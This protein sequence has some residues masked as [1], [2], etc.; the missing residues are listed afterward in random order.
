[1]SSG[2]AVV[3]ASERTLWTY[4]LFRNLELYGY[5]GEI[6]PVNPS[7]PE[8]FGRPC[9]ADLDS[10]PGTPETGV[11]VV[12]P[13]LA[14]DAC[15]R[16]VELGSRT[17]IVVS[18]GFRESGTDV[19]INAEREMVEICRTAGVRMIG[20]NCVGYASFHDNMC[21]IAEPVPPALRAGDVTLASHSGAMISGVLGAL[22]VEALGIDH[23]FSIGNAALFDMAEA[24][25]AGVDSDATRII[26]AVVEGIPPRDQLERVIAAGHSA[27]KEFVFLLLAQSAGGQKVA[28]SHTGAVIGEQRVARAWLR[29]LGV[30]VTSSVEEMARA[31]NIVRSTGRPRPGTGAFVVTASGG[32]AGLASDLAE[33]HEVPLANVSDKTLETMRTALPAGAYAGNPLDMVAGIA[34]EARAELFRAVGSDPSVG[35]L[36][37]PYT[38]TWPDDSPGRSWHRSGF[39]DFAHQCASS[40]LPGIVCSIYDEPLT[41]WMIE[42]RDRTGLCVLGGLG[43][44]MAA[45]GAIYRTDTTPLP[46]SPPGDTS[47]ATVIGEAEGRALLVEAGLAVV[48]GEKVADSEAATQVAAG[49]PGPWVLKLGLAGVGHKGRVGGVRVGLWGR[50]AVQRAGREIA[51]SAVAAGLAD[52]PSAVPFLLQ[53]M[54]TGPEI[55]LG[56]VRDPIAGPSVTVSVGGWA[57]EGSQ[58]FGTLTLPATDGEIAQEFHNWHLGHL[59]GVD[60][61]ADLL[62]YVAGL[63]HSFV[64]GKLS[65]YTVVEINPLILGMSGAVAADVLIVP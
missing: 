57:A 13:D 3:G 22:D 59:L 16:L 65:T 56:A 63:C 12:R 30:I 19:G 26:C 1:M 52:H 11:I 21:A 43:T 34:P 51:D 25:Q 47:T 53:E 20:P 27:G 14:V 6:W 36:M 49:R 39:E 24:L 46:P 42:Y 50:D 35:L 31:A 62:E 64:D 44:T 61:E 41:D 54:H 8:V 29:K 32:G 48:P 33:R 38:V 5:D 55:L 58:P 15:R 2:I 18:N 28:A 37:E 7:R 23:C 9:F 45:L 60:R 4:W 10:I 40:G 17:V